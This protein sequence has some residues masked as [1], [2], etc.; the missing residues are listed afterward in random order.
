MTVIEAFRLSSNQWEEIEATYE[1]LQGLTPED[2]VV[3]LLQDVGSG[4]KADLRAKRMLALGIMV[5]RAS[6]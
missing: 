6:R 2:M 3:K 4:K 5:R 1:A